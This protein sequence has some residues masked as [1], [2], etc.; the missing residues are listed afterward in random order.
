V[1]IRVVELFR[2]TQSRE[3]ESGRLSRQETRVLKLL[4]KGHLKKTA[5]A[6]LGISFHTVSFHFR[7]I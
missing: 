6:E 2:R 3:Q 4:A 1:A 5:A 7:A